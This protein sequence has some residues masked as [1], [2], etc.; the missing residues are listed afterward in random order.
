MDPTCMEADL[1][2]GT[3]RTHLAEAIGSLSTGNP[4]GAHYHHDGDTFI[5]HGLGFEV[6]HTLSGLGLDPLDETVLPDGSLQSTAEVLKRAYVSLRV[7][8]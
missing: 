8:R 6:S 2:Y 1:S 5:V 7:K 3:A 4:Q